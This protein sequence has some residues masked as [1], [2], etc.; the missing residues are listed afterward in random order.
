MKG[1]ILIT[2]SLI[3]PWKYCVKKII[4]ILIIVQIQPKKIS[5]FFG[6]VG[7]C[8][9]ITLKLVLDLIHYS[10]LKFA[11]FYELLVNIHKH[12]TMKGFM[13]RWQQEGCNAH[14]A[15]RADLRNFRSVLLTRPLT[16]IEY[17]ELYF[18]M[19]VANTFIIGSLQSFKILE[20]WENPNVQHQKKLNCEG[21]HTTD[22][23][24]SHYFISLST[25]LFEE[26][27]HLGKNKR[28]CQRCTKGFF[29]KQNGPKLSHYEGEKRLLIIFRE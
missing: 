5:I 28:R 26:L 12:Y 10:C 6:V 3:F 11:F 2:R 17:W 25:F 23:Y 16:Y 18:S 24:E 4:K 1:E 21:Y 9:A 19:F 8:L 7:H 15:Q 20:W 27:L 29:G 13:R 14:Q 22:E